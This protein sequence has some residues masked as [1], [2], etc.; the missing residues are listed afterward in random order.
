MSTFSLKIVTWGL[1]ISSTDRQ[2]SG[3]KAIANLSLASSMALSNYFY[4][5]HITEM[6]VTQL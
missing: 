5:E 2:G 3:Q 1:K 4:I 6:C